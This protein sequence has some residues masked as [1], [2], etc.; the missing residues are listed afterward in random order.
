MA[1][2]E[3]LQRPATGW[4]DQLLRYALSGGVAFAV[5]FGLLWLC[6]DYLGWYYQIGVAAGYLAGLVITYTMA[7]FWIFDQHRT[8]NRAVEIMGFVLIGVVGMAV[9]H[10]MMW[11]LT[12]C[13]LGET[14]YLVAKLLTTVVVSLLNFVLKKYILFTRN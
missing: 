11:L 12:D 14:W 2:C 6:T 1:I 4:I 13:W 3:R 8:D 5:D 7:T 9:T 10:V